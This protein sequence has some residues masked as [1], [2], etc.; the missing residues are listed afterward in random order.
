VVLLSPN[1]SSVVINPIK[2]CHEKGEKISLT[3]NYR[4]GQS[5]ALQLIFAA[6]GL[7][8]VMRKSKIVL[9]LPEILSKTI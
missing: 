8:S 5:A 2:N 3:V 9:Q 1:Q 7:F 6:L 4:H